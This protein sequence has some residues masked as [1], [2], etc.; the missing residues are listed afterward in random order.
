MVGVWTLAECRGSELENEPPSAT[1]DVGV[2]VCDLFHPY[3]DWVEDRCIPDC[4]D[5]GFV[6]DVE[7]HLKEVSSKVPHSIHQGLGESTLGVALQECLDRE[8]LEW[9]RASKLRLM[10]WKDWWT[11]VRR[12]H[13]RYHINWKMTWWL[14]KNSPSLFIWEYAGLWLPSACESASEVATWGREGSLLI[15]LALHWTFVCEGSP[16]VIVMVHMSMCTGVCLQIHCWY[17][18]VKVPHSQ[19]LTSL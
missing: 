10:I 16:M 6:G 12:S 2:G 18:Y 13:F 11:S 9:A 3:G 14:G 1:E 8:P 7:E 19:P 4:I 17:C 15:D 5:C